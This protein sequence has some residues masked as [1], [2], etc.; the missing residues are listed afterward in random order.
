MSVVSA[1]FWSGF[2]YVSAR[3]RCPA[4]FAAVHARTR[5]A[6]MILVC[7]FRKDNLCL[8]E[9]TTLPEYY[10]GGDF[11]VNIE[12]ETFDVI[13]GLQL[14]TGQTLYDKFSVENDSPVY[15][16]CNQ[17][18]RSLEKWAF[19][20]LPQYQPEGGEWMTDEQ[21]EIV[22]GHG[23]TSLIV[24]ILMVTTIFLASLQTL[25]RFLTATYK[26][27]GRDQQINY[28]DVPAID[29]YIPQV[30]SPLIAYPL[31]LCNIENIDPKLFMWQDEDNPYTEY[32]VTRD[33]EKILGTSN[34]PNTF[35]QVKHWGDNRGKDVGNH[36]SIDR[37]AKEI[38]RKVPEIEPAKESAPPKK[39]M[40]QLVSK[41]ILVHDYT[42]LP[43]DLTDE[44]SV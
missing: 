10:I 42:I 1:Y 38:A 26:P 35:A 44:V 41:G 9:N 25:R 6:L 37:G 16:Y 39:K 31:L 23:W 32:D 12:S 24:T 40:N 34:Y 22:Y 17:D 19:P 8:E 7:L 33:V 28:S 43:D 20:A 30:A 21:E 5:T 2:P 3:L 15:K 27:R 14:F 29:C 11:E 13:G 4:C 36:T 18:L